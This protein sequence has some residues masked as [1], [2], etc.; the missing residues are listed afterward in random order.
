[1]F[2]F[3]KKNLRDDHNHE[4]KSSNRNAR[5]TFNTF[6]CVQ[7]ILDPCHTFATHFVALKRK[8]TCVLAMQQSMV[9]MFWRIPELIDKKNTTPITFP[10]ILKKTIKLLRSSQSK[11]IR[12]LSFYFF[13]YTKNDLFKIWSITLDGYFRNMGTLNPKQ[14]WRIW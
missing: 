8:G 12:T 4:H 10:K 5:K 13:T 14:S 7:I 6:I 3:T 9:K 11:D 2:T 1:M